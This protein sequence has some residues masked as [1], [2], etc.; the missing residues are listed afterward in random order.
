VKSLACL[1][2]YLD[3]ERNAAAIQQE[4]C[5]SSQKSS[6][7]VWVAPTDECQIVAEETVRIIFDSGG[8]A[9]NDIY[10]ELEYMMF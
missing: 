2:I 10:A 3:K 5:I 7:Q 8:E 1:G 6:A 4:A 9:R